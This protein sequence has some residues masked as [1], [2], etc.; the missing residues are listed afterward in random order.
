M[1]RKDLPYWLRNIS[2]VLIAVLSIKIASYFAIVEDPTTNQIFKLICRTSMTFLVLLLYLKTLKLGC[3]DTIKHQNLSGLA[4][5]LLYL[6]IGLASFGWSTNVNYSILQWLMTIESLVFVFFFLRVITLINYYFPVK[7]LDISKLFTVAIFPIM[8]IFVVGSILSPG[9]FFRVMRGGDE[10]RLGGYYMNSNELGM[11]ASIGVAMSFLYY[12]NVIKKTGPLVMLIAALIVL[13][14]TTSRSSFIGLLLI[15][16][17]LTYISK[18]QK[19]KIFMY[20]TGLLSIPLILNFVIFK[21]EGGIGEVLSMT[22]RIPFWTALLSEGIIREPYLG[23]GFMR[24]DYTEY[25]QSTNTYSGSMA[26]NTFLQVLLNLGFVGLFV[27]FWQLIFTVTI[28][29]KERK[30]SVYRFFFIA[31]FIP[32]FINS[33]TEFGIF[34]LNN[35]GILFYQFLI[36]LFVFKVRKNLSKNENYKLQLFQKQWNTDIRQQ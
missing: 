14:L 27:V 28:F 25:F 36:L 9:L 30:D 33:I 5:Y 12:Q 4:L 35:F 34:G 7:K 8:L 11:L 18:N 31:L 15:I 1:Y 2:S 19:I 32:I 17:F 26:H 20:V 24:I 16:G 13:I 6:L 22:G 29:L 3:L 21:A 10:I 23:F